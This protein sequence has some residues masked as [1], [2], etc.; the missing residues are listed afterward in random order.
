MTDDFTPENLFE[1]LQPGCSHALKGNALADFFGIKRK[2]GYQA[3][4]KMV[5]KMR[6]AGYPVGSCVR[7]YYVITNEVELLDTVRHLNSRIKEIRDAVDALLEIKFE[8]G[9]PKG[10]SA[11]N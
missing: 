7:G 5:H 3:V 4:R 11:D 8:Q 1:L 9:G 10:P 6:L 2:G